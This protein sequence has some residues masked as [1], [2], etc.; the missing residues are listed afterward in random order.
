MSGCGKTSLAKLLCQKSTKHPL[1]AHPV[2]TKCTLLRGK[3]HE[4]MVG[5]KT[6]LFMS[7]HMVVPYC[8]MCVIDKGTTVT[9]SLGPCL[10]LF[11]Q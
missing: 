10:W 3:L 4:V 9:V 7:S 6:E 2:V 1:Y 11:S 5:V 8:L